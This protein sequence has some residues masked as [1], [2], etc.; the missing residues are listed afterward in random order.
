[1]NKLLSRISKCLLGLSLACGI[2]I[3]LGTI[4]KKASITEAADAQAYKL[5]GAITTSSTSY[6][7]DN[8]VTQSS[9]SWK[10]NGNLK[11][12]P[13]RI[14][15]NKDNGLNTAGTI[16]KAQS[17]GV[18]SSQN[19][20]KVVVVTQ[21]PSSNSI[22]PTNVSLK[23]G[24]SAGG[25][26]TSSLSNGSWAATVTFNR[27]SDAT[28]SSKYFEIDFTMPANTT[29]T[30]KFIEFVSA[31]FYYE[32]NVE[33]TSLT[34][35]AIS[36][37]PGHTANVSVTPSPNGSSLP[38]SLNYSSSNTSVFTVSNGVVT[39]VA[40]GSAT[41]RV[42]SATNSSVYGT[43]TVTV[44]GYPSI[45]SRV[46]ANGANKY[47]IYASSN[48]SGSLLNYSLSGVSSNIGTSTSGQSGSV[49][50]DNQFTIV[51]GLYANTIA[52]KTSA[53]KYFGYTSALAASGN[54][55]LHLL[56]A[57]EQDSSWVVTDEQLIPAR[58]YGTGL[59]RNLRFNY[60]SGNPRFVCYI[61]TNSVSTYVPVSFY[62][63]AA[64][65]L[66]GISVNDATIYPAHEKTLSVL[67]V[68]AQASLEGATYTF[69]SGTPGVAT[70]DE[71][72]VV[73]AISTGTTVITVTAN[74]GGNNYSTTATITVGNY[75]ASSGLTLNSSYIISGVIDDTEYELTGLDTDHNCGAVTAVSG[76]YAKSFVIKPVQGYYT[77][78]IAFAAI[79]GSGYLKTLKSSSNLTLS[80]SLALNTSWVVS[81]E[82]DVYSV[83]SAETYGEASQRH[84]LLNKNSGS[85]R[86]A[87]YSGTSSTIV[88]IN[89]LSAEVSATDFTLG[90]SEVTMYKSNTHT[91][92][93]T[94]TPNNTTDRTLSW[95]S[96]NTSV[97]TVDNGVITGVAPGTATISASK[98]ISGNTVTRTC[99][100]TVLNNVAT[101][102][103]TLLD[104]YTVNEAVNIAKGF[105]TEYS[106]GDPVN[107]TGAYVKGIVT[108]LSYKTTTSITFWIGD[109]ASETSAATNGFEIYSPGSI[110]DKT[111]SERYSAVSEIEEDFALGNVIIA[112][113]DITLYQ[114][115]TAEFASG[116]NVVLNNYIEASDFAKSFN[117]EITN[118]VCK[119]DGSTDLDDLLDAWSLQDAAY[120]PLHETSKALF[121]AVNENGDES[122]NEI[123]H[124]VATYDYILKKYNNT[125][126]STFN[127]FMGRVSGNIVTLPAP[128]NNLV[129]TMFGNNNDQML[130]VIII[131][132][133]SLTSLT[134]FI[135]LKKR[136]QQ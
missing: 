69:S 106:N 136:K 61:S 67:P 20:S 44:N 101:H 3:S 29:T 5:D 12:N 58:S 73:S 83:I 21:K 77:N 85:P 15:G 130:I 68:P 35:G 127:D 90:E 89:F 25:S 65:S 126:T 74:V 124:A 27:P 24:T 66:T 76:S 51:S 120:S 8:A 129:A 48:G 86:I 79:D 117:D 55:N 112:C 64:Q 125:E 80:E 111:V 22:S 128:Y 93:V 57:I 39:G 52:I 1:M 2:G 54:N 103:G 16:R 30:N 46:T 70:V 82:N 50:I 118:G 40:A 123:E 100:V 47:A 71:N 122:G 19:I 133:V 60:N 98:E 131:S 28:W 14:G 45:D 114:S 63:I 84:L 72:G 105:F 119:A 81:Y 56:D 13:W 33:A 134:S 6:A 43:A 18:V 42:E 36:T 115:T 11:Q 107:K 95:S 91:L 102:A 49:N 78:T 10:V 9:V 41:L 121:L 99:S 135:Y 75:P 38:A 110:M 4:S 17:Q 116:S 62:E 34:V 113:G 92:E 37:Y 96:S 109:N 132:M 94:F 26:Q 59:E 108:N 31:T 88:N 32:S 7:G 87:C 97:A 104:P 53:N 23:V